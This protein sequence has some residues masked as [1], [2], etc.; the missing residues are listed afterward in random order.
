MFKTEPQVVST[1]K[2]VGS[3]SA[4]LKEVAAVVDQEIPP[5]TVC[6]RRKTFASD[7]FADTLSLPYLYCSLLNSLHIGQSGEIE[8]LSCHH[9]FSKCAFRCES[10]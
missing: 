10:F 5:S 1:E 2:I 3:M 8:P 7:T 9:R 6:N 4:I